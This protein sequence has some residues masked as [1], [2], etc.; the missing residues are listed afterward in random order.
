MDSI[1]AHA[2]EH[3][4]CNAEKAINNHDGVR[5]ESVPLFKLACLY[6]QIFLMGMANESLKK[7][8]SSDV[9]HVRLLWRL[10]ASTAFTLAV[11]YWKRI[12]GVYCVVDAICS[13]KTTRQTSDLVLESIMLF[14]MTFYSFFSAY[15]MFDVV[16]AGWLWFKEGGFTTRFGLVYSGNTTVVMAVMVGP[17]V[18]IFWT[19]G[20]FVEIVVGMF[21]KMFFK[22]S[23]KYD[24]TNAAKATLFVMCCCA[25]WFF[26]REGNKVNSKRAG[27]KASSDG[28]GLVKQ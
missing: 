22:V 28:Q 14:C 21:F 6:G 1:C 15:N 13:R 9:P 7:R 18:L 3:A 5:A 10:L 16:I 19:L 2:N 23:P 25:F 4:L 24:K 8:H 27:V 12:D 26:W 17:I 20:D 11:L